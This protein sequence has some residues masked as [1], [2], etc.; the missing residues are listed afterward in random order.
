MDESYYHLRQLCQQFQ[1]Y[2]RALVRMGGTGG[3][4]PVNV[5]QRVAATHQI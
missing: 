2:D 3:R 5:R 1:E 4:P